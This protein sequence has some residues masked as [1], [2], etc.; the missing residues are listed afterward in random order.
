MWEIS[1]IGQSTAFLWSVLLGG[2]LSVVYDIF[3]LDRMIFK[4]SV[5]AVALEDVLFFI[6]TAM[7]IFCLQLVTTNGQIRS[8]IFIGIIVGFIILRLTLSRFVDLLL[9][10]L[11]KLV[12][13]IKTKY[14]DFVL[15][16][17]DFDTYFIKALQF[18]KKLLK[19]PQKPN[20]NSKKTEKTS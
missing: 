18:L 2:M 3:R 17:A 12:K 20:E 10:P 9:K 1:N 14:N 8:F 5:L 7:S 6:I 16:V 15:K 19:K 11:K 4:R 13:F